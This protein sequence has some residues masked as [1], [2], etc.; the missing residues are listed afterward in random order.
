MVG[1]I[2]TL[3]NSFSNGLIDKILNPPGSP[4]YIKKK[5]E[6]YK[7]KWTDASNNYTNA[8]FEL[9]LA[10]K[11]F[12]VY[13]SGEPGGDDIY[14]M[15]IIDRFANTANDLRQNSI[16]KQ[17]EF[18]ANLTESLNQYQGEILFSERTV[19]LLQVRQKENADLLKKMEMYERILQTSERKVV[20]EV[21]DADSL[22]TWRRGM[23]FLYYTAIVCYIIFGNFIPDKLYNNKSVWLI[24][25][26]VSLIPI[27]LNLVIKWIFIIFSVL[28]YWFNELPHKDIYSELGEDRPSAP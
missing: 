25:V 4:K 12:Y 14:N 1:K 21:K 13:N 10:E 18:M 20:Y 7:R 11:N 16:D 15:T 6:E 26:I 19:Q 2:S 5:N 28:G 8:P 24:I 17:Q 22:H 23:L 9:S 27:I 3:V